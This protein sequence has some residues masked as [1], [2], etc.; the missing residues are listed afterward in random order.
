MKCTNCQGEWTPP[1]NKSLSK[2]PFCQAD[3]LQMLN[4]QAEV[5]STEV[6]LANMLQAYSTD[7]LQNQQR[8]VAMISDLFAH[9]HKTKRLLLLSVRENIP[10]QLLAIQQKD[11]AEQN[12]HIL[13]L[14]HRLA[15][16]AFLKVEVAEQIVSIWSNGLFLQNENKTES[17]KEDNISTN[18]FEIINDVH[19]YDT[20]YPFCEG[21]AAVC[22]NDKWGYINKFGEVIIPIKYDDTYYEGFK[23]GLV[24]L[25]ENDDFCFFDILGNLQFKLQLQNCRQ[26]TYFCEGFIRVSYSAYYGHEYWVYMNKDGLEKFSNLYSDWGISNYESSLEKLMQETVDFCDGIA[27]V[28]QWNGGC[29]FFNSRFKRMGPWDGIYFENFSEG[30][31]IFRNRYT[32]KYGFLDKQCEVIIPPKYDE[33]E[34]FSNG[35]A[36]VKLNG[37]WGFIDK[38]GSEIIRIQYNQARDFSEGLAWVGDNKELWIIDKLGCE[39]KTQKYDRYWNFDK[40]LAA[41]IRNNKGGFID[42]FGNEVIECK[43]DLYFEF[44]EDAYAVKMNNK[45]GFIDKFGKEICICKYDEVKNFCEDVAAVRLNGLWGFIDKQGI[46]IINHNYEDVKNFK[47]GFACVKLNSRWGFI[48]KNGNWLIGTNQSNIV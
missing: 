42:R 21:L 45:W 7:L 19:L 12:T 34:N 8:L 25:Q 41:V 14:Q 35:L 37:K 22:K 48:D 6:I 17:Q 3:I 44:H 36:R 16:E 15:E 43:Y 11:T 33:V 20:V 5:L 2:C 13:A 18:H 10:T 46:E 39:N 24:W 28:K 31:A 38:T 26:V 4:E 29:S 47:E 1:A 23:F 9:D 27:W 40:E 30:A 32:Y